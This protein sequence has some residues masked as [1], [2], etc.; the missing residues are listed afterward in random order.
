MIGL[1]DIDDG[2]DGDNSVEGG[3]FKEFDF[4]FI[5]G[6]SVGFGV[7]VLV[8]IFVVLWWYVFY[9]NCSFKVFIEFSLLIFFCRWLWRRK[10]RD[11][12]VVII[13]LLELWVLLI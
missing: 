9:L 13:I 10:V 12:I 6:L 11:G 2:W 3:S 4:G 8:G 5:I 7:L 1:F